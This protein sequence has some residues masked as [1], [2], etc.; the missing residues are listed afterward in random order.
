MRRAGVMLAF[1][2]TVA[3]AFAVTRPASLGDLPLP[4]PGEVWAEWLDDGTPVFVVHV[5]DVVRVVGASHPF[6]RIDAAVTWCPP[7]R[8]F[9]G[10]FTGSRFDIEGEWLGGPSPHGLRTWEARPQGDRVIVGASRAPAPRDVIGPDRGMSDQACWQREEPGDVNPD[11]VLQHGRPFHADAP[12]DALRG[13]HRAGTFMVHGM[14]LE[15]PDGSV[16]F[17]DTVHQGQ[18]PR[19]DDEGLALSTPGPGSGA[20]WALEGWFRLRVGHGVV[21]DAD[22]LAITA[23]GPFH[24]PAQ[25]EP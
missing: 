1:G 22:F 18:P 19:C 6:L 16:Q 23:Y 11:T 12:I 7:A 9:I 13:D 25:P 10:V 17:C 2:L 14:M 21:H 5:G 8:R 3:L 15:H 24:D 20:W 4:P